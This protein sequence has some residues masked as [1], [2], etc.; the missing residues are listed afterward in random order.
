[1]FPHGRSLPPETVADLRATISY[2]MFGMQPRVRVSVMRT[3]TCGFRRDRQGDIEV[4]Y[5]AVQ[6]R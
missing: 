2:Q 6:L 4:F 1:M 5:F 3:D